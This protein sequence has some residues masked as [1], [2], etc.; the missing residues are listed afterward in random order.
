MKGF[1]ISLMILLM[2]FADYGEVHAQSGKKYH[3]GSKR[4]A[5]GHNWVWSKR[6]QYVSVGLVFSGINYFGDITPMQS[7]TSTDFKFSRTYWGLYAEKR[8]HPQWSW[9][10]QFAWGRVKGSDEK[11]ASPSHI[12][13]QY[14]YIR[15]LSFRNDIYEFTITG[16]FDLINPEKANKVFYK[17]TNKI[18]PYLVF[19]L[20][21]FYHNPKALSPEPN[22]GAPNPEAEWEVDKWTALQPL[23]TE[24]Q[25]RTYTTTDPDTGETI[26]VSLGKKYSKVQLAIPLGIG[27]RK[28]ISQRIDISFEFSYRYLLTDYLDDV[29][30][31]YVDQGIFGNDAEG[32]LAKAFNDRSRE[33]GR[34]VE[35]ITIYNPP[36]YTY[37]GV[38]GQT[39]N[40]YT[41][42]GN[43]QFS[44]NIRGNS[45]DRD[46]YTITGFHISYIFPP[47]GIRCPIRFR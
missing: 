41:G 6:K 16:R 29:S 45:N 43:T 2:V 3:Y 4:A 36:T 15:N 13:N 28:K 1:L 14:R 30:G 10:A 44:D 31:L 47:E 46:V 32:N 8:F 21:V 25:G 5:H 20:G 12:H 9:R 17:R 33:G 18:V 34:R 7:L 39:Y 38:D 42:F 22:D 11:S 37:V 19:G 35:G 23:G 24:G 40:T 26:E 27:I